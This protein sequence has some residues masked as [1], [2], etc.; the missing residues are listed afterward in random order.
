LWLT[1]ERFGQWL[2]VDCFGCSP[3]TQVVALSNS[4][5]RQTIAERRCSVFLIVCFLD[6]PDGEVDA[7]VE[8]FLLA[9]NGWAMSDKCNAGKKR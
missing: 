1:G 5:S 4:V 7:S 9:G 6:V 3:G 2:H 8:N